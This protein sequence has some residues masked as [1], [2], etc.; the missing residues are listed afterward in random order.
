MIKVSI[1]SPVS[2]SPD[3]CYRFYPST[4]TCS[5]CGHVQ[6]IALKERVFNCQACGEVK[7][8]DYNASQNLE[9]FAEGYSV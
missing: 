8:R 9:R 5:N 4:K 7:D 1:L 6:Q 2:V 3:F